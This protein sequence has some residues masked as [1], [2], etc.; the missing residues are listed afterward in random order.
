VAAL[1][2]APPPHG[3]HDAPSAA[4]ARPAGHGAH[5]SRPPHKD[6]EEKSHTR[7]AAR[8][9]PGA[10]A[11]C[12]ATPYALAERLSDVRAVPSQAAQPSTAGLK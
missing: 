7:G 8:Y 12:E 1:Q 6:C 10:H 5:A 11:H 4:G 9:V 3:T 2:A